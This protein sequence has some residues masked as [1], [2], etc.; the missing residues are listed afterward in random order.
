MVN[1]ETKVIVGGVSGAGAGIALP[2]LAA[3]FTVRA[4][5]QKGWAGCGV[6][7]GV[8][9]VLGLVFYGI[10][11]RLPGIGTLFA[12][13]FA[14]TCWG[15]ILMDVV[16]AAYP[17]GVVGLAEDA[18]VSARVFVAGGRGVAREL[19]ELE[20]MAGITEVPAKGK[21]IL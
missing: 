5:G 8:K 9:A 4:T 1:A 17:G 21:S 19:G 10:S 18:A 11:S 13:I 20:R 15:S 16:Q 12:E 3:E 14:Y 7:A 6:K 2:T